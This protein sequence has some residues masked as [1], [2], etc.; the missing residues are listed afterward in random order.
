VKWKYAALAGLVVVAGVVLVL[1]LSKAGHRNH[2][3]RQIAPAASSSLTLCPLPDAHAL[4]PRKTRVGNV[5]GIVVPNNYGTPWVPDD[6]LICEFERG[7][8][9][10]LKNRGEQFEMSAAAFPRR[11]LGSDLR[12]ARQLSVL[13]CLDQIGWDQVP[14]ATFHPP[15][16]YIMHYD[17]ITGEY[18]G[19]VHLR[20]GVVVH[21]AIVQQPATSPEGRPTSR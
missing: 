18:S 2:T 19:P 10:D 11:Y 4:A 5:A 14:T 7:L 15:W 20:H 13:F 1:C 3:T 21:E 17:P 6:R 8:A 9:R 12:G 16:R